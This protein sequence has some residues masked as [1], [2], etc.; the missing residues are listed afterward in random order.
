MRKQLRNVFDQYDRKE[1]HIT[2]SLLVV[3]SRNRDLLDKFLKKYNI[4]LSEKKIN[5]LSQASPIPIK[6][7]ESVPDGYIYTDDYDFCI[8]IETKIEKDSLRKEQLSGHIKQLSDFDNSFLIVISPDEEEPILVKEIKNHYKNIR[9]VSWPDL[10]E[11]LSQNGPG[12]KSDKVGEYL[13]EEFINYMERHYKMT[14]FMGFRF[15]GGYDRDLATHYVKKVSSIITPKIGIFYPNCVNKR[16]KISSSGGFPWEAWYY[17][18]E[19][20]NS[21]HPAFT[22]QSDQLRCVITL[23]NGAK[24]EWQNFAK[25]L[26]NGKNI[27]SFKSFL[28]KIYE[29]RVENSEAVISIRQRH[30]FHQQTAVRDAETIITIATLLGIDPS[31]FNDIWWDLIRSVANTK[32]KYN[33]QLEIGYDLQYDKVQELSSPKAID[34]ILKCFENLKP[35]YEYLSVSV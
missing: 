4:K 8:G 32:T 31:K 21:L 20:R 28:R 7:R 10:L 26:N 22:V 19:P 25:I 5:L 14:P 29:D 23:G 12:K 16:S 35:L 24:R 18:D 13:F 30:Y 11:F 27:E 33:Y 3:F 9:F 1:N 15:Q 2:H 17:K 34:I 6:E